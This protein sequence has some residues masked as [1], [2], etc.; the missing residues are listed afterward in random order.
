VSTFRSLSGD[1]CPTCPGLAGLRSVGLGAANSTGTTVVAV[2]G[3]TLVGLLVWFLATRMKAEDGAA[4]SSDAGGGGGGGTNPAPQLGPRSP[5]GQQ[6]L[7][8]SARVINFPQRVTAP[9]AA[10]LEPVVQQVAQP[11][12][13][14]TVPHAPL[15]RPGLSNAQ[16]GAI[17]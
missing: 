1:P 4:A 16:R 13:T 8:A 11:P 9:V 5:T 17:S 7:P 12:I 15:A 6:Q 10:G 2:G 3:L 14:P